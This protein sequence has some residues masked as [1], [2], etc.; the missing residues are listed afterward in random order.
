MPN[1]YLKSLHMHGMTLYIG[2]SIM[3]LAIEVPNN[4]TSAWVTMKIKS[5]VYP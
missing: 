5:C 4:F 3:K 2:Y 1:W